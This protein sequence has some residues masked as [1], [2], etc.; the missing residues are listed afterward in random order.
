MHWVTAIINV[1]W[2]IRIKVLKCKLLAHKLYNLVLVFFPSLTHSSVQWL[3]A[4]PPGGPLSGTGDRDNRPSPWP[5]LALE[6]VTLVKTEKCTTGHLCAQK[7]AIYFWPVHDIKVSAQAESWTK[8]V[9]YLVKGLCREERKRQ[10]EGIAG[11]WKGSCKDRNMEEP[12]GEP[13]AAPMAGAQDA[14]GEA[15]GQGRCTE[16]PGYESLHVGGC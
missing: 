2:H 16:G 14:S 12:L 4:N 13:Q 6:R 15:E 1:R 9:S 7:R 8:G 3:S 10:D 5:F 11:P